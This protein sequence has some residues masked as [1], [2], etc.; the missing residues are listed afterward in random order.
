M[1]AI[2]G[3]FTGPS[4]NLPLPRAPPLEIFTKLFEV[5][6]DRAKR[7][8]VFCPAG[9]L[10]VRRGEAKSRVRCNHSTFP[11][12]FRRLVGAAR[13]IRT[14]DPIIT[15]DVNSIPFGILWRTFIFR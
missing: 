13:G 11:F 14:P 12:D 10:W 1:R 2:A 15:N 4:R 9:P 8:A 7:D 5:G 3:N 6:G